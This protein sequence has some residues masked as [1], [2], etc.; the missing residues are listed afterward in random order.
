MY[1]PEIKSWNEIETFRFNFKS[2]SCSTA[3]QLKRSIFLSRLRHKSNW[4]YLTDHSKLE[5][6]HT[7]RLINEFFKPLAMQLSSYGTYQRSVSDKE[8]HSRRVKMKMFI[9][10]YAKQQLHRK[11]SE[12]SK[13]FFHV[14]IHMQWVFQ[15]ASCIFASVFENL[16]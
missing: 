5:V 12:Y 11:T 15:F 9:V 3:E 4:C 16:T 14:E 13:V 2:R 7:R 8:E 10:C 1:V 6:M